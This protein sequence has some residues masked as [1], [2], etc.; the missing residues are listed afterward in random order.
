VGQDLD[1]ARA[2]TGT[3]RFQQA[4]KL[5]EARVFPTQQLKIVEADIRRLHQQA[6]SVIDVNDPWGTHNR[7]RCRGLIVLG[8]S[9]SAKSYSIEYALTNLPPIE[10]RDGQLVDAK[11][12]MRE[13]PQGEARGW[14][15]DLLAVLGYNMLRLPQPEL[16]M[17]QIEAR[18]RAQQYTILACDE[19]SRV[20][21][22]RNFPS[23]SK[24][25]SQSEIVWT[26]LIQIMS[27]PVWPT[28]VVASGTLELRDTL[29]LRLP[30]SNEPVARGDMLRRS[31]VTVL[32]PLTM[33]DA[34]DLEAYVNE[35]CLMIG[36]TNRTTKADDIGRRLVNGSRRA[37]GTSLSW[38]QWAV[39]LASLRNRGALQIGD[40]ANV[41]AIRSGCPDEANLFFLDNWEDINFEKV[42]PLS[43]NEAR[44]RDDDEAV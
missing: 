1:T 6:A 2:E 39:A 22:P 11:V 3:A 37:I 26:Q 4:V 40:F 15:R 41:M 30:G 36:V 19:L 5:L 29:Q 25:A 17:A 32:P 42:A 34:E 8:P 31:D 12:L 18:L 9:G 21:N 35:Y 20:L 27:D 10:L 16:A 14:L 44:Y 7:T 33:D 13:A 38:A 23:R 24:L 28:P 43:F